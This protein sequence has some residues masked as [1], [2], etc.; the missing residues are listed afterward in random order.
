MRRMPAKLPD[1]RFDAPPRQVN[2]LAAGETARVDSSPLKVDSQQ[3]CFI[4]AVAE[5]RLLR[6]SFTRSLG[7]PDGL[8]ICVPGGHAVQG[9]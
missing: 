5:L 9:R 2:H 6:A 1:E 8:R 7:A 3:N 4:D